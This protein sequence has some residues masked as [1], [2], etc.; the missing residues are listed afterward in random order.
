MTYCPQGG[1][2]IAANSPERLCGRCLGNVASRSQGA[3]WFQTVNQPSDPTV[4]GPDLS[5]VEIADAAQIASRLPQFDRIQLIGRGGMGVVYKARQIALD[6]IV[7]LKIL[8]PSNA[9][10]QGFVERF[11]REARSLAKLCHPNIVMVYDFGATNGLYYLVMEFVDGVDLRQMIRG[12]RLAPSEA[13]AVIPG[14]CDAL[15]FAHDEGVVHRDIK[16]ENILFDKKGRVKIAD[17]GLAKILGT[18]PVDT[19]LTLSGAVM[20]TPRYMAPEQLYKPE[21]VDQRADIYSLGVVFYEML[22]GEM[23]VGRFPLPSEKAQIDTRLDK[24]VLRTLEQDVNRRYQQASQVRDDLEHVTRKDETADTPA[25]ALPAIATEV[26]ALDVAFLA[27][28]LGAMTIGWLGLIA[29]HKR[30]PMVDDLPSSLMLMIVVL[31]VV[32][33]AIAGIVVS[34]SQR[35]STARLWIDLAKKYCATL[36]GFHLLAFIIVFFGFNFALNLYYRLD[37]S[38]PA[39]TLRSQ[40]QKDG[41]SWSADQLEWASNFWIGP[42]CVFAASTAVAMLLL[43]IVARRRLLW[44]GTIMLLTG[45]IITAAMIL[46]LIDPPY[47]YDRLP[48]GVCRIP[49]GRTPFGLIPAMLLLAQG[50]IILKYGNAHGPP[51]HFSLVALQG[52]IGSSLGPLLAIAL[53]VYRMAFY[54]SEISNGHIGPMLLGTFAVI[55]ISLLAML[56]CGAIAIRQIK[57]P[58]SVVRGLRLAAVDVLVPLAIGCFALVCLLTDLAAHLWFGEVGSALLG[59]GTGLLSAGIAANRTWGRIVRQPVQPRSEALPRGNPSPSRAL[60]ESANS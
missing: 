5:P 48:F 55:C 3:K 37:S 1:N 39:E 4:S 40:L 30:V 50:S 54:P 60:P 56:L 59:I 19:R 2:P 16:P 47:S 23:P 22:T 32:P 44:H 35:W 53:I 41:I 52:L 28:V 7:A 29:C 33:A 20:G 26:H 51:P 8:P 13:L 42:F 15:Q 31:L 9:L 18:E 43:T 12:R 38:V 24:I 58:G 34:L 25:P 46:F 21:S 6:R 36:L 14:I 49:S 17:F 45:V 27:I 11:Q 57:R 10:T